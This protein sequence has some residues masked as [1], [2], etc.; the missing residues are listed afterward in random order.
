MSYLVNNARRKPKDL[1]Q[2][3]QIE[4]SHRRHSAFATSNVSDYASQ[5]QE[6]DPLTPEQLRLLP[7]AH[8]YSS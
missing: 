4:P 1:Q 5:F 3:S 8:Q 7:I 6:P 2:N